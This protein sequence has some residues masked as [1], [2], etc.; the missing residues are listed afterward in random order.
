MIGLPR[1]GSTLIETI[2]SSNTSVIPIGENSI[3]NMAILSQISNKIFAK[4]L[5]LENFSLSLDCEKLSDYVYKKI[6]QI[7]KLKTKIIFTL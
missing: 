5:D 2:L 4:T 7:E 3:I 1:S 6:K